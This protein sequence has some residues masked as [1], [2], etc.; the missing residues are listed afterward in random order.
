MYKANFDDIKTG[1]NGGPGAL[2]GYDECTGV[3]SPRALN[4]K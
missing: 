3:G 2:V 1:S 4:G